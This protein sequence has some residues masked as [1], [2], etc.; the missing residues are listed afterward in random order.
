MGDHYWLSAQVVHGR[1]L[2]RL[3]HLWRAAGTQNSADRV[4]YASAARDLACAP[5]GAAGCIGTCA[6]LGEL[7]RGTNVPGCS[8][9]FLVLVRCITSSK[10]TH[11]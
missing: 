3:C 1:E 5:Y 4:R 7:C 2:P 6:C 10:S 9:L 11:A 8:V